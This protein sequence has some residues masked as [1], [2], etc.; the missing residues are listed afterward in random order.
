M[1]SNICF[2]GRYRG[3]RLPAENHQ[4]RI[5]KK[6]PFFHW[7][8]SLFAGSSIIYGGK[9]KQVPVHHFSR[10]GGTAKYHLTN[11][12]MG[13][14]VDLLVVYWMKKRFCLYDIQGKDM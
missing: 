3:Y 4:K 13:P 10:Y 1:Y 8:A 11:R 7:N 5:C 9:V 14:F 6:N 2:E 12:L